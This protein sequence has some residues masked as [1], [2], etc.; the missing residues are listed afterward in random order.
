MYKSLIECR[1]W[2]RMGS[3][4]HGTRYTHT[5][6]SGKV[7]KFRLRELVP[8]YLQQTVVGRLHDRF[9]RDDLENE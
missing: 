5:L 2:N 8:N 7:Q 6:S 1:L 9:A 3:G 4:S